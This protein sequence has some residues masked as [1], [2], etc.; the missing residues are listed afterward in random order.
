MRYLKA[1]LPGVD[2]KDLT[3]WNLWQENWCR[4]SDFRKLTTVFE[5]FDTPAMRWGLE[6]PKL[7]KNDKAPMARI[8]IESRKVSN[9]GLIRIDNLYYRVPNYLV[10]REVQ[11][12]FDE[13]TITVNYGKNVSFKLDKAED[14]F[15]LEQQGE[16]TLQD[17]SEKAFQKKLQEVEK[18]KQWQEHIQSAN[19]LFADGRVYDEAVGWDAPKEK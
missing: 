10:G 16:S 9:D 1:N 14:V 4:Q 2:L 11:V 5:G 3:A 19:S 17:P 7:R 18:D 6:Q 8:F 13:S 12:Q 15:K